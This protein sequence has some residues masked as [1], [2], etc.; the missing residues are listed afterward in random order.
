MYQAATA[1]QSIGGVLDNGFRLYRACVPRV[2]VLGY[3]ASLVTQLPGLMFTVTLEPGVM[4][5]IPSGL[6]PLLFVCGLLATLLYAAIVKR[7]DAVASRTDM[8]Q[9]EALLQG[10]RRLLPLIASMVLI[11]IVLTLT[12]VLLPSMVYALL[13][14]LGGV[15]GAL[16]AAVP[17]IIFSLSLVFAM[18][19]VVVDGQG[20]L[21]ALAASHRLVWGH[22]WRTAS[23]MT[24]VM[25]VML[26]VAVVTGLVVGLAGAF[27][28]GHMRA[29][30]VI[31]Q[32]VVSPLVGAV[33]APLPYA[34]MLA[35]YYDLRLRRSGADLEQRLGMPAGA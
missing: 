25:I 9:V 17:G 30:V 8:T 28:A 20:P 10:S 19:A 34:L 21:A 12:L 35:V 32:V 14:G 24:V 15:I 2:L 6:I 16:V 13:G 1:P 23:I 18:F 22:W 7:L 29:V 11:G 3:C 31:I 27:G 4:P 33:L 5:T 26:A